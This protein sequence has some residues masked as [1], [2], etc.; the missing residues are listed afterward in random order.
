MHGRDFYAAQTFSNQPHGRRIELGWWRTFTAKDGMV[1]NQSMS[2]PMEHKL[3]ET[4]EGIRLT[5]TPVKEL[6]AL[7][8]KNYRFTNLQIKEGS[9]NPFRNIS[10]KLAE[11]HTQFAP[12]NSKKV[13]LNVRGVDIVF[14]AAKNELQVDSVA[15]P[16]KLINGKLKLVI[17][18]DR[19]GVEIFVN[20]GLVFMP[21]N[22][23]IDEANRQV[24]LSSIGG[25]VKVDEMNVYELKSIWN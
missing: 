9:A 23:N 17:F 5:R 25:V 6:E 20:D 14:D 11:L 24:S 16:V 8:V 19:T 10:V 1:F 21:V 18:A 15:A 7:R 2:I 3:V 13:T 12:G 22:I 4:P